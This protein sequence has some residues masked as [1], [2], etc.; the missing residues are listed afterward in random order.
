M[1]KGT[2]SST[3]SWASSSVELPRIWRSSV[4][5]K[6][7]FRASSAKRGPTS[8]VLAIIFCVKAL[9]ASRTAAPLPPAPLLPAAAGT[10]SCACW[11]GKGVRLVTT[12]GAIGRL[13]TSIDPQCGH[14]ISPERDCVSKS[15]LARNQLSNS[16]PEAHPRRYLITA[17][18]PG[19]AISKQSRRRRRNRGHA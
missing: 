11:V 13:L 16:C 4:S 7:I 15:A 19:A 18:V 3:S 12:D 5:P 2:P 14:A 10:V 1:P 9:S 6:C 8:S 17:R